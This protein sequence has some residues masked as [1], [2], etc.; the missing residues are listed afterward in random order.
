MSKNEKGVD[1]GHKKLFSLHNEKLASGY[2]KN[3]FHFVTII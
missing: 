1:F 3:N 2:Q